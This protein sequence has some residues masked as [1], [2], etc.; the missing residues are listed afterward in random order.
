MVDSVA[1]A[2]LGTRVESNAPLMSA[3]LDSLA[4][5]AFVSTLA[6][7]LSVDIAPTELFDH[8]TLASI[9]SRVSTQVAIGDG[10]DDTA[11]NRLRCVEA[12]ERVQLPEGTTTMLTAW[13]FQLARSLSSDAETRQLTTR[14]QVANSTVPV[15]RWS[16]P[17]LGMDPS[18]AYG[19]FV[20][21]DQLR[22]DRGSFGISAMEA[23]SLDPQQRLVLH[24]GYGAL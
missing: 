24:V 4:A 8:P 10:G 17:A 9:A 22:L 13:S 2:T 19:S 1:L 12:S 18:A 23:R 14:M 7:R 21:G 15:A 11:A 5:A 16:T 3:G 20:S 6:T